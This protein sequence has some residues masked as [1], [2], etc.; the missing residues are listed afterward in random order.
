MWGTETVGGTAPRGINREEGERVI[1]RT[2]V[3]VLPL[4]KFNRTGSTKLLVK[5]LRPR[6]SAAVWGAETMGEDAPWGSAAKRV[7]AS[8][9]ARSCTS[10]HS[11]RETAQGHGSC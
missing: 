4:C 6:T 7:S 5:L 3:H 11:V 1:L 8:Y 10:Y 2:P 9:C